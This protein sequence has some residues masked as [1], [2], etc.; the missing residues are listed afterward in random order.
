MV[1]SPAVVITAEPSVCNVYGNARD[2]ISALPRHEHF[3][4]PGAVHMDAE[5]PTSWMAE[6]ICG[7]SSDEKRG[8]F[9]ERAT[10]ALHE[11]L[12]VPPLNEGRSDVR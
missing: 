3:S 5:W 10:K 1:L 8:E 4:I 2:M 9:R 12:A 7:R 11:A 6:L